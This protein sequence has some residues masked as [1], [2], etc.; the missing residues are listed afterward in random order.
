MI[1][2]C[3]YAFHLLNSSSKN[4][5]LH[6]RCGRKQKGKFSSKKH[7]PLSSSSLDATGITSEH[8]SYAFLAREYYDNAANSDELAAR[9]HLIKNSSAFGEE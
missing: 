3:C 2:T 8:E 1:T 5:L 6:R 7:V 9:G 4:I